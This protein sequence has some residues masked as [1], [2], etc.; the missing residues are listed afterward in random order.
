RSRIIYQLA[1]GLVE[2]GHTVSL[3]GTGDSEVPG[4]QIIPVIEKGWVDLPPVENS[5]IRDNANLITQAKMM[6]SLQKDY[7]IIH[8]HTYP[9]I[10][11][12]VLEDQ[13]TI[14]L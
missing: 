14:P 3:L 13:L 4:V 10:F 2:K 8:N 1:K 9:D 11:P 12:H 7:D 5:V 6:I